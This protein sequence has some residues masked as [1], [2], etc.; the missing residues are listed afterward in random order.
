MDGVSDV[1][2][3]LS[4]R[5]NINAVFVLLVFLVFVLLSGVTVMNMLIKCRLMDTS[6][7]PAHIKHM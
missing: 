4:S 5:N 2:L 3:G 1:L 7:G 6:I